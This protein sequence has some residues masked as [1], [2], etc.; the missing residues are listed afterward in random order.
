MKTICRKVI[1]AKFN[2]VQISCV[3]EIYSIVVPTQVDV[4]RFASRKDTVF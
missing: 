4:E 3:Y 1:F 2:H